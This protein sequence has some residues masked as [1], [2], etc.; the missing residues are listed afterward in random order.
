MSGLGPP[1]GGNGKRVNTLK[2]CDKLFSEV[3]R[4]FIAVGF[5]G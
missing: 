5:R 2:K 3:V 1:P 4:Y